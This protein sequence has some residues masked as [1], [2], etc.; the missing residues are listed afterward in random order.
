MSDKAILES[1]KKFCLIEL[2]HGESV[3]KYYIYSN[4]RP[5]IPSPEAGEERRARSLHVLQH[6]I[7][8]KEKEQWS[9]ECA[10]RIR[11]L[12]GELG[13]K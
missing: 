13:V 2:S 10:E 1:I 12:I 5:Y 7:G 3:E 8:L 6:E 11:K 9:I 4:L